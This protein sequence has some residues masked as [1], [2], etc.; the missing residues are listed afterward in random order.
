MLLDGVPT[1]A[2]LA[3]AL[4]IDRVVGDP[5]WLWS[6]LP[7]PVVWFGRLIGWLDR[8]L[9]HAIDSPERRR[10]RG[11]HALSIIVAVAGVIGL[12][13]WIVIRSL[14]PVGLLLEVIVVAIFLAQK[15]LA[16]HVEAVAMQLTAGGLAAGRQAVSRI[17]GRDPET[18]DEAGVSRAAIESLA[19]NF[20]DGVVAPAL[21][22]AVFGLP[23]LLVYKML[24]T[25]DS[26][27]GHRSERYLDFGRAAAIADDWANWPAARLSA[28]LIAL[29]ALLRKGR[30]AALRAVRAALSDARHH[31]SP[32]AG[33]PEAAMAGAL[34][35]SL[36]GPRVYGGVLVDE[37]MLHAGG[38]LKATPAVIQSALM[39]FRTACTSGLVL[40][41]VLLIVLA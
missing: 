38:R 18:L 1:L 14:G 19:E 39:L 13:I 28:M 12:L 15:S 41:V 22:Y 35:V 25:A 24:N 30:G 33:W 32:N 11:R 2:I 23:G 36:A 37:P 34:D 10:Q 20:S 5:D 6:R 9:N 8:R 27:I 16:D 26:M 3:L 7:H 21:W 31:R 29:A 17:V 4:L 40:I